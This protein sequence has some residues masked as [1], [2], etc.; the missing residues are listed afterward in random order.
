MAFLGENFGRAILAGASVVGIGSLCYYGLGL[1][2]EA[3]AI[4][5]AASGIIYHLLSLL[6]IHIQ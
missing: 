2:N 6:L 3:G 5:K 4:D 1:S